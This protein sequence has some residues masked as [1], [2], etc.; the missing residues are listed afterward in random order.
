VT[1]RLYTSSS[2][3]PT[4]FPG[5]LTQIGTATVQVADQGLTILNIPV[6]GSAP[7]GSELVVEVF[8]PDGRPTGTLFFIGSNAGGQ[9]GP[10][11]LSAADCGVTVPTTTAAIGF[12]NMHIVMNVNGCEQAPGGTGPT[13]T[14]TVTVNDTQ[15]PV[16]DCPDNVTAVTALT[17]PATFSTVVDFPPP[18]ASDN[19]PG[20]TVACVP[21]SG[22][23]F[24]VGTTTVTCTATDASG[25]T[26]TCSFTVSVF[27]VC[28]QDDANP[29]TKLL[30]NSFSGDYRFL[31]QGNIFVGKGKVS[32][33][34]CNKQLLHSPPGLRVRANWT[35]TAKAGNASLQV[36][37]GTNRCVIED[38]DMTDNDCTSAV[39]DPESRS[40]AK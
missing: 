35:T 33:L 6:T 16:I 39:P 1:V 12:P 23:I 10:S 2:A 25:N 31:C 13:C 24:P 11:F 37:A 5:S 18:T 40:R 3:F 28:L 30:I 19:C 21:A 29:S 4:G 22:T 38:R 8:T 27:D 34:A 9:T 14:F 17:C 32:G 26:A 15:P 36:P 7:A 20:V